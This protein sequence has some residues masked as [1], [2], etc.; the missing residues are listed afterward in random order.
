[1]QLSLYQRIFAQIQICAASRTRSKQARSQVP[2]LPWMSRNKWVG[3]PDKQAR[4]I[5]GAKSERFP[6]FC[7]ELPRLR[8]SIYQIA[9]FHRLALENYPFQ[10]ISYLQIFR[11]HKSKKW[12]QIADS[13]SI[14]V[15]FQIWLKMARMNMVAS[16][17]LLGKLLGWYG[18]LSR[19][20]WWL[21]DFKSGGWFEHLAAEEGGVGAFN[22]LTG[23]GSWWLLSFQKWEIS[24]AV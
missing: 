4:P 3:Q 12:V 23:P 8:K 15:N 24:L 17:N 9:T 6:V 14:S 13:I 5:W 19:W 7:V 18:S 22:L 20:R 16:Y 11:P 10:R 21:S 1:M 2:Q